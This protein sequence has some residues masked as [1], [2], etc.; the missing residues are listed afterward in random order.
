MGFPRVS[1]LGCGWLGLPLAET[2]VK[3]GYQVKGSTTT[4]DKIPVLT[5]AGILSF[6]LR[7]DETGLQGAE[8]KDFLNSEILVITLPFRRNLTDPKDYQKQIGAIVAECEQIGKIEWIIFTSSTSVYP[9]DLRLATEE[10]EF[11][12]DNLR[13][14]VLQ[15]IEKSLLAY[16]IFSTTI[17]RLAGL[18]G[19]E[20][21]I[22]QFLAGKID[23]P[24]GEQP[25]N[26]IHCDDAVAVI[27]EIIEQQAHNQIF[28]AVSDQHPTRQELYSLAA[29]KMKL[30]PPQFSKSSQLGKIVSNEKIKKVLGYT[31]IHP[32]PL[33]DL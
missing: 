29:Q 18:Y 26:L 12:A 17:V 3:R 11:A 22:G 10:T 25:V 1:I 14:Q 7:V 4:W 5:E 23:L 31:F 15:E 8:L 2:L 9:D 30:L 27:V 16:K 20:R 33:Q 19:G 24:N 6:Y 32:D 13:S 28:N 21:K